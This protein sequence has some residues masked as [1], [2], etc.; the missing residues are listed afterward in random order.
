MRPQDPVLVTAPIGFP[1]TLDQVKERSRVDGA[2]SDAELTQ[3]IAA[4]TANVEKYLKRR[5]LTQTWRVDFGAFPADELRLPIAPVQSVT[6]VV[7]RDPAGV[8][9]TLAASAYHVVSRA[10]TTRIERPRD[11]LWPPTAPRPDAV[12]VTFVAGYG[13]AA[14]VPPDLVSA[15]VLLVGDLHEFRESLAA[16]GSVAELPTMRNLLAGE[17]RLGHV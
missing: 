1:V 3:M 11:T 15:I 16:G 8:E 7:Y 17:R 14:A 5:L 12:R 6:S 10:G 4:A 13:N 2:T 9:Q